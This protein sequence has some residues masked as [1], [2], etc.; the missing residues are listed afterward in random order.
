MHNKAVFHRSVCN[1]ADV[2]REMVSRASSTHGDRE[3]EGY[4]H[5][6]PV[7]FVENGEL[8]GMKAQDAERDS[9]ASA[10]CLRKVRRSR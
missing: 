4:G 1:E 10:E 6:V 9:A 3:H 5:D 2:S 8:L 7:P